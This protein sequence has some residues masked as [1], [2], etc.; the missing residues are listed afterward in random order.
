MRFMVTA[1]ITAAI[2]LPSAG[3]AQ[4]PSRVIDPMQPDF[5]AVVGPLAVG[6]PSEQMLAQTLTATIAGRIVGV[7]L[8]IACSGGRLH[9]ELRDT[10]NGGPGSVVLGHGSKPASHLPPLGAHFRLISIGG[11]PV[12]SPG[13]SYTLVLRNT[14]GSCGL[15]RGPEGDSYAGGAGFFDARPNP[16]GWIPFSATETRLDLPFLVV[17]RVP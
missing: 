17:V 13:D 9:L 10:A 12:L 16:P 3:S 15:L 2:L 4:P 11:G 14:G 6:G 5:D 7:F 8:P 1:L